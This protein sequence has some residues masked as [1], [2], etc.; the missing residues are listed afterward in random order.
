MGGTS[1]I[2]RMAVA[3]TCGQ[4]S[5]SQSW[6]GFTWSEAGFFRLRL[7]REILVEKFVNLGG[8]SKEKSMILRE[9][10]GIGARK[11]VAM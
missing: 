10:R 3:L 2:E 6:V 9:I 5:F 8:Y 1:R 7:F 4:A 11:F